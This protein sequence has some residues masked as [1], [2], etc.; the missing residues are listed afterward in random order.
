MID[1]TSGCFVVVFFHQPIS[2]QSYC[3]CLLY[4]LTSAKQWVS[5]AS[6]QRGGVTHH[7][8]VVPLLVACRSLAVA[9]VA[10]TEPH[11]IQEPRAAARVFAAAQGEQ[12][13]AWPFFGGLSDRG[14]VCWN[15]VRNPRSAGP[16]FRPH[17]Y[18]HV[19]KEYNI[20]EYST[21]LDHLFSS[22]KARFCVLIIF[23]SFLGAAHPRKNAA[24]D[25][26][27]LVYRTD[28]FQLPILEMV[29]RLRAHV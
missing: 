17:F 14:L 2:E 3:C 11:R 23:Q 26:D 15:L 12:E 25:H 8:S 27:L 4:G 13:A 7:A 10:C 24:Y 21:E 22:W 29:R 9:R 28:H 20:L 18:K 19:N 16:P 1:R 6:K 5:Y